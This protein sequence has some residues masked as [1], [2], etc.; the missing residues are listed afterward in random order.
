MRQPILYG[1]VV[2]VCVWFVGWSTG[3]GGGLIANI[4]FSALMGVLA[5]GLF[6]L[7]KKF[8]GGRK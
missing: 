6:I 3:M 2:F 1:L 8:V 7:A 4:L 5:A